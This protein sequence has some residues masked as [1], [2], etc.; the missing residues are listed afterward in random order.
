V[1]TSARV[2]GHWDLLDGI[3][4]ALTGV[5]QGFLP[6]LPS[7]PRSGLPHRT[8]SGRRAGGLPPDFS[9]YCRQ[10]LTSVPRADQRR[11]GELYV[12]GLLTVPGRKTITRLAEPPADQSLQQFVNQSPWDWR[13]VRRQLAEVVSRV[14][15]ARALV[16]LPVFFPKTGDRSVGVA[17]QY[18]PAQRRMLRGQAAVSA[19]LA[20]PDASCPVDWDLVLPARWVEDQRL[21]SRAG[22]PADAIARRPWDSTA[23]MLTG[24]PERLG[25]PPLPV[26]LDLRNGSP[27]RILEV[28]RAQRI[29]Y[30]ARVDASTLLRLPG[31]RGLVGTGRPLPAAA[32]AAAPDVRTEAV[33]WQGPDQQRRM[34]QVTAVPVVLARRKPFGGSGPADAPLLLLAERTRADQHPHWY[35]LTDMVELPVPELVRLGKLGLRVDADHDALVDERGLTDFEGRSYRGWHHHVTLVSA[36]QGYEAIRTTATRRFRVV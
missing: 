7:G 9:E 35:T 14:I 23:D 15:G 29:P 16:V 27:L 11:W 26:V 18:V 12:R 3:R 24:L 6:R 19:W 25:V 36:A 1:D 21:R 20:G 28:L 33:S 22:I 8:P 32:V 2:A 4:P 13:P 5:S 31:A 30:V 17:R 34:S 10:V